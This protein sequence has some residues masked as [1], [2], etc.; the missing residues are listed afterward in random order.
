VNAIAY[1]ESTN[2]RLYLG[3]D[4][5]LYTKGRY[6]DWEKVEEFPSV[7]ITELKINKNFDK[8]RVA[9]FGRGLWEGPLAE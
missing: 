9:T 6:S 4:F 2:D 1:H 7:R 3:T 8:L 5:G